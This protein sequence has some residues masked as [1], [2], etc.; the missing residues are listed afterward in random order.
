MI[1]GQWR[2]RR[3]CIRGPPGGIETHRSIADL[4][5]QEETT[6]SE[7]AEP[8]SNVTEGYVFFHPV[9]RWIS[10]KMSVTQ[11]DDGALS[12]CAKSVE[13]GSAA[14]SHLF[15]GD[16]AQWLRSVLELDRAAESVA[17]ENPQNLTA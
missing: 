5:Q 7:T 12:V 8:V 3:P 2:Q 14:T 11:L 9:W 4:L 17:V 10:F 1:R 6:M 15:T 13:K 16:D